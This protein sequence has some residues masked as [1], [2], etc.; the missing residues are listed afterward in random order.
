M[1]SRLRVQRWVACGHGDSS[2]VNA[3]SCQL[4]VNKAMTCPALAEKI[5][6]LGPESRSNHRDPGDSDPYLLMGVDVLT[7]SHISWLSVSMV[8]VSPEASTSFHISERP[9]RSCVMVG[10]VMVP[11]SVAR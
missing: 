3:A 8:K 1:G 9:V 4:T 6:R 5:K 2:Q 7:P 10:Y 11:V